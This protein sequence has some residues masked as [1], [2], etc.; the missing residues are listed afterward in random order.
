MY[1]KKKDHYTVNVYAAEL[2]E[3]RSGVHCPIGADRFGHCYPPNQREADSVK[4]KGGM[5]QELACSLSHRTD[6]QG[7]RAP[8]CAL[9]EKRDSMVIYDIILTSL[10]GIRHAAAL[11][12]QQNVCLRR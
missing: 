3:K 1:D 10:F 9:E 7:D 8:F 5:T 2:G 6:S 11:T 12:K 4:G